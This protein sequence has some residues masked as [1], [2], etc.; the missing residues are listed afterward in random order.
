M[1]HRNQ[2]AGDLP[3]LLGVADVLARYSLTD[4]RAARR[5]M[6]TVGA[7]RMG[8]NLYVRADALNAHEEALIAARRGEGTSAAPNDFQP[9][10]GRRPRRAVRKVREPLPA[11]WWREPLAAANLHGPRNEQEGRR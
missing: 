2:P 5:I 10:R 11:E 1:V 7:F 3:G 4:R 6:D 9:A 8:A